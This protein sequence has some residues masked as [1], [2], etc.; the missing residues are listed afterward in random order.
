MSNQ[1][2]IPPPGPPQGWWENR[3]A[4]TVG[5]RLEF[6]QSDQNRFRQNL[7][8]YKS[9]GKLNTKDAHLLQHTY[10]KM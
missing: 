9:R 1:S 8:A 3:N 10:S 5:D 6:K 7:I 2:L 4:A